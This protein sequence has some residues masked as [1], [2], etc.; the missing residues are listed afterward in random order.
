M[1]ARD[2]RG[3]LEPGN[4]E[5]FRARAV[6]AI[7]EG[8]SP[9][10]HLGLTSGIGLGLMTCG[11][12][13]IRGLRWQELSLVPAVLL[14]SNAV[15]WRAHRS[16]LHR[17]VPGLTTLFDR[18]TPEHHRI[19]VTEDMAVRSTREWRL[20]M[21]PAVGV[22]AIAALTAP[23]TAALALTGRRNLAG[24]FVATTM[25]YV[26]SYEWL[27][28]AYHLPEDSPVGGLRVVR[29][30]RRHHATHHDPAKMQRWNFNVTVPL[31]DLVRGTY[32][33]A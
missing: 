13:A 16:V 15:E 22:A 18:H 2:P 11:L 10:V 27:H 25:A 17:R 7:P 28:L 20:V 1:D 33:R 9:W 5:A 12:A 29:W 6:A 21:V 31:W 32:Y 19:F 4:R 3:W 14:A 24:L 8:Y 30:L 23:I 26:V